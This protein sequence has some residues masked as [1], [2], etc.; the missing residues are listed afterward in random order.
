V[1]NKTAI[2]ASV[3]I[4]DRNM[5]IILDRDTR[6]PRFRRNQFICKLYDYTGGSQDLDRSKGFVELARKLGFNDDEIKDY[7]NYF[8]DKGCIKTIGRER[9]YDAGFSKFNS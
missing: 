8:E 5:V 2:Y 3:L 6:N 1:F 9:Q 4:P 7:I